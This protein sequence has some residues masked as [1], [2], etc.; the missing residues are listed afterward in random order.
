MIINGSLYLN[1]CKKLLKLDNISIIQKNLIA[2][3]CINLKYIKNLKSLGKA[4]SSLRNC[5]EL[6]SLGDLEKCG[7]LNLEYC[8]NLQDLGNLK[9]CNFILLKGS[10]ITKEYV[11]ENYKKIYRNCKW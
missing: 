4:Y 5:S 11:Q 8:K 1:S 7:I 6:I 9:Q 3:D 10:N 2:N